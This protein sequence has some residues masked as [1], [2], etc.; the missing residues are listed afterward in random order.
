MKETDIAA[1]RQDLDSPLL[2]HLLQCRLTKSWNVQEKKRYSVSLCGTSTRWAQLSI[3]VP[4]QNV[5]VR[6]YY[7]VHFPICSLGKAHHLW[8]KWE[9][10]CKCP[11][12]DAVSVAEVCQEKGC[13]HHCEYGN[14]HGL[15]TC[16]LYMYTVSTVCV[17]MGERAS[18]FGVH[19]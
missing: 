9:E 18:R 16:V 13:R 19:V 12:W 11:K 14:L 7:C 15:C 10:A 2:L 17:I 6:R 4:R 3:S 1:L 8:W 5:Q